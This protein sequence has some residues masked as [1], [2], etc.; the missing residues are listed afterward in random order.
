MLHINVQPPSVPEGL[1][2][3]LW[4]GSALL[5]ILSVGLIA[6]IIKHRLWR[7]EDDRA[8]LFMALGLL[9]MSMHAILRRLL[10]PIADYFAMFSYSVLVA[11]LVWLISHAREK[12][13]EE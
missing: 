2:A 1:W 13:D 7:T 5:A 3:S 11:V 6:V 12:Q 10:L 4:V 9:S 8:R